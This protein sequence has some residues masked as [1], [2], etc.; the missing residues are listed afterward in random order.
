LVF[1]DPFSYETQHD[2]YPAYRELL[3]HHPLYYNEQRD[4]WALSRFADVQA[5]FRDWKTFSS[6][7]GVTA[8]DLLERTGPSLLTMDPPR[9]DQ[10]R[11]IFHQ[12]FTPK[13]ISILEQR[14]QELADAL[15]DPLYGEGQVDLV[16]EFAKRLPVQVICEVLGFPQEDDRM[17]KGWSDA[18]L[19]RIP[20]SENA[21]QDS[22][23][24]STNMRAYFTQKLDERRKNPGD[25]LLS[26]MLAASI[27]GEPMPQEELIGHCFL[28]F[29]AGNSTTTSLISNALLLLERHPDQRRELANDLAQVPRAVEEF[30]RFEA[31]VQNMTRIATQDIQMYEQT[32]PAGSQVI[33]VNGAANRDA[34]LWEDP[35]SLDITRKPLRNLAFGDGIHHCI[36]APL[37]RLEAKVAFSTL[38][39]KF[40]EYE[41]I[42][43]ERFYDINERSLDSM[44][45]KF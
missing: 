39:A 4:F 16:H 44:I 45:V 42:S 32:I 12:R 28:F 43:F 22:L 41:V 8:D 10:L 15:L 13:S 19:A 14:I 36:G 18:I 35:D 29:I 26:I 38:L 24:G 7:A 11:D 21:S 6:S 5:A 40:P 27:A 33:L 31:P 2:P 34:A 25:D 20:N 30:L 3:D 37:A 9:H 23:D 1:Y 17:L